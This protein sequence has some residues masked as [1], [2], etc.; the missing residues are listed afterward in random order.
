MAAVG[1]DFVRGFVSAEDYDDPIPGAEQ[2]EV[3]YEI[4]RTTWQ[5]R[6]QPTG[7]AHRNA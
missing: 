6:R 7:R 5:S 2:G 1:L 4:T 3:E